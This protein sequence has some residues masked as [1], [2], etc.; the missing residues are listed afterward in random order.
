M[1]EILTSEA[2]LAIYGFILAWAIRAILP[3]ATVKELIQ[4]LDKVDVPNDKIL[5]TAICQGLGKAAKQIEKHIAY[6]DNR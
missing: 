2:A 3:G 4:T 6:G 1:Y 5:E